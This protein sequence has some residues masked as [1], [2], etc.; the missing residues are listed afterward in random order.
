[1]HVRLVPI[2]CLKYFLQACV[3]FRFYHL[4][5]F[6]NFQELV[7]SV[8]N[9]PDIPDPSSMTSTVKSITTAIGTILNVSKLFCHFFSRCCKNLFGGNLD[10]PITKKLNKVSSDV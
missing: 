4:L 5:F 1:M 6:I 3:L 8:T 2:I 10:F 7:S 9:I